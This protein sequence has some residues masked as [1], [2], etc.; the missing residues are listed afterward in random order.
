M[1]AD[2]WQDSILNVSYGR[3]VGQSAAAQMAI[4]S[5]TLVVRYV[6]AYNMSVRVSIDLQN[7]TIPEGRSPRVTQLRP[8]P[9]A[10]S[11]CAPACASSY[12]DPALPPL[13]ECCSNP[14]GNPD[15]IKPVEAKL[16]DSS[17]FTAP[18]FSYTVITYE[19]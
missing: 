9:D 3:A 11:I 7:G 14:P 15:L 2:S 10:A 19:R 5:S 12:Y 17:S 13:E 16:D 18:A 6:N 4:D 8:P 1:I